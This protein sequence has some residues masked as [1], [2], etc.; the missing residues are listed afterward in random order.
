MKKEFDTKT[1]IQT[2]QSVL[3]REQKSI[4]LHEPLFKGN[5]WDYVKKCLDS[6]WVSSAGK[7]VD[8]FEKQLAEYTGIKHVIAVVNGTAAL[9]I[10][11]QLAGVTTGDEVLVPALTFVATA[12]AVSHSGAIPHFVDSEERTLGLDPFK[13]SDYLHEISELRSEGCF[14]KKSGR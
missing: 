5:E 1:I 9:D 4:A 3:P 2:I 13:L 10:C 8:Y 11:L 6:G 7:H 14:N 12:N